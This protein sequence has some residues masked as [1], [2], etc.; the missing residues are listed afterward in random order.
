MGIEMRQQQQ[1]RNNAAEIN[2]LPAWE[3]TYA[4]KAGT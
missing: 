1:R 4:L 3:G 2:P